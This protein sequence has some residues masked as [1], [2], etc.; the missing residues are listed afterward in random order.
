MKVLKA[1]FIF[2]IIAHAGFSQNYYTG[3]GGSQINLIVVRPLGESLTADEEFVLEYIQSLLITNFNKYTAIKTSGQLSNEDI[4]KDETAFLLIGKLSRSGNFFIL[5]LS[6]TDPST[7]L[8]KASHMNANV[9]A[10]DIFNAQAIIDGF[11]DIAVKL[12][13]DLTDAGIAAA[14]NPE[15]YEIQAAINLARGNTAERNDNPIEML[16]YLYN[17][18]AYDPSLLEAASRFDVFT[19]LLSAGDVGL[20]VKSDLENRERWRK[21]LDEFDS[22]YMEHPPFILTFNPHP[23]QRGNT[24]YDNRT[25]VLQFSAS[26]QEDVSFG[27]MQKVFAAVASGLKKT[28]NQELWGFI[29]RP[30][31]SPLLRTYRTYWVNAELVNNR[32]EVAA[33]ITFTVRS[34]IVHRRN[35]LY[36]D[37]S[38]RARHSFKPINVDNLLTEN[39]IVRIVSIDGIETEKAMEDGYVKIIPVENLPSNKLRSPFV[40]FTRDVSKS[41]R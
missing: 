39:M 8:L 2:F 5:D 1:C 40:L 9:R 37:T 17:A 7:G 25:A 15:R 4:S 20:S 31:R 11:L 23:Y 18:A 38:Q 12:G 29:T 41:K 36:A 13:V 19:E 26:F 34:R 28:G 33:H 16:T 21:I 30:Y 22:F 27:A 14:K 10:A 3:D 32:D 6:A 35:A 24:D